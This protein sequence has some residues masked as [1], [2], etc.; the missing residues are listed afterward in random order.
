MKYLLILLLIIACAENPISHNRALSSDTDGL[1]KVWTDNQGNYL[2]L[3]HARYNETTMEFYK[4]CSVFMEFEKDGRLE[5]HKASCDQL[6]EGYDF[7]WTFSD[8][9]LVLIFPGQMIGWYPSD[10]PPS[11][12]DGMPR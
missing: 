7:E 8:G 5:I 6:P 12:W 10:P 1:F 2:D 3:R 9:A 11:I 4:N